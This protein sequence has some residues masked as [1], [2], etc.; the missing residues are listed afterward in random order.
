MFC[1]ICISSMAFGSGMTGDVM[2]AKQFTRVTSANSNINVS[3]QNYGTT[4]A[5]GGGAYNIYNNIPVFTIS[6][7]TNNFTQLYLKKQ[8]AAIVKFHVA[9]WV[10]AG[11]EL[12]KVSTVNFSQTIANSNIIEN[13]VWNSGSSLFDVTFADG[14]SNLDSDFS[15]QG[16]FYA[17][18]Y[19][20]GILRNGFGPQP[21]SMEEI[22]IGY[23][24][25][26]TFSVYTSDT[27]SWSNCVS[28]VIMYNG[29][30]LQ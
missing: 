5:I 3:F 17:S 6:P 9:S 29:G 25:P 27:A 30:N 15:I 28:I 24:S 1:L 10:N 22:L 23:D 16:R 7:N 8:V 14:Y 20:N 26:S 19:I 13:V 21:Q 4:N 11:T 18:L 2:T 12:S